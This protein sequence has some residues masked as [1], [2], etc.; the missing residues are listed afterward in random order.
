MSLPET[1]IMTS[2]SEALTSFHQIGTLP[3]HLHNSTPRPLPT[4]TSIRTFHDPSPTANAAPLLSFHRLM[5]S[6]LANVAANASSQ[7]PYLNNSSFN[8]SDFLYQPS[9]SSSSDNSSVQANGDAVYSDEAFD[10]V[11]GGMMDDQVT[12]P[13]KPPCGASAAAIAALSKKVVEE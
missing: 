1:D 10:R 13:S 3:P 9:S 7:D 6:M 8:I 2:L 11:I 5:Q 12:R 4:T